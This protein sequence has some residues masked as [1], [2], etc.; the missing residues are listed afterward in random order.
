MFSR[1][2]PILDQMGAKVL[3]RP[4]SMLENFFRDFNFPAEIISNTTPLDTLEFD[5]YHSVMSLP[6]VFKTEI[7]TIPYKEGYLKANP[8]KVRQFREKYF[9]NDLFKIGI[10]WQ[11]KNLYEQDI[12]RSI[13]DISYLFPIA[14]IPSVKVYSIQKGLGEAQLE[15][16]P[17]EIEIINLGKDLNDFSDTAAAVENLDLVVSVDTSVPHLSGAMGKD[18]IVMI[19]YTA[20]WKWL[21][22]RDDC[23]W[24]DKI[25]LFRQ[26]KNNDWDFVVKNVVEYI[27]SHSKESFN[28][29]P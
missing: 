6:A 22:D 8:E 10:V 7:D 3:F 19:E 1:Y 4:H 15:N 17:D 11:C 5:Y 14:K 21:L 28:K 27:Q 16:L 20:D 18:T 26:N 2:V 13:P 24:Y 29:T 23:V 9:N 12:F 25:R